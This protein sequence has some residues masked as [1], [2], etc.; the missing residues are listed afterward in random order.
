MFIASAGA[1]N[2]PAQPPS[3]ELVALNAAEA[4]WQSARSASNSYSMQQQVSCFCPT[5]GTTFEVFVT[6]GVVSRARSVQTGADVQS[7]LL[8][9][10][11]TID[12]LF[13]EVRNA[14]RVAGTL[15]SVVY[16]ESAGFPT[17]VSLDPIRAAVDDEVIYLT[18]RV[19]LMP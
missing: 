15:R 19:T 2:N 16:D 7:A 12:A 9:M 17:T 13:A 11:R 8:T 10:F 6:N 1:C 3:P 4:R 14:L 5:G 18:R